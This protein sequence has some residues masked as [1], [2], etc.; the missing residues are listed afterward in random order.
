MDDDAN[1]AMAAFDWLVRVYAPAFLRMADL[2]EHARTLAEM[3]KIVSIEQ[4]DSHVSVRV[5]KILEDMGKRRKKSRGEPPLPENL[6]IERPL[7]FMLQ[8]RIWLLIT[9]CFN[10]AEIPG[11]MHIVATDVSIIADRAAKTAVADGTAE[12][13][14][15]EIESVLEQRLTARLNSAS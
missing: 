15:R 9:K 14:V 6:S 3:P 1:K 13:K 5:K 8:D 7:P 12:E 2:E 4:I 10:A 11:Y